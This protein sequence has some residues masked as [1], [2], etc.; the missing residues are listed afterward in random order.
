MYHLIK[1]D[2]TYYENNKIINPINKLTS[3]FS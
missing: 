2:Q 3:I 1:Q